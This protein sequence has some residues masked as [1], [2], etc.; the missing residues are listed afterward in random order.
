MIIQNGVFF[1]EYFMLAFIKLMNIDF[2]AVTT[3]RVIKTRKILEEQQYAVYLTRDRLLDKHGARDENGKVIA[4]EQAIKFKSPEDKK[5]FE[6]EFNNLVRDEFEIPLKEKV[7]LTNKDKINGFFL[8]AI[9]PIAE[10]IDE[11][12]Q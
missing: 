5:E 7:K 6:T 8:E 11:D 10:V 3:S 1:N 9:E 12:N 2:D 4:S